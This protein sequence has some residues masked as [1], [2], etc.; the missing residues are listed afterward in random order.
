MSDKPK[1]Y[2]GRPIRVTPRKLERVVDAHADLVACEDYRTAVPAPLR[3]K[4]QNVATAI[5]EYLAES[6]TP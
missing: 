5:E 3:R 1:G 4:I 2:T 6:E